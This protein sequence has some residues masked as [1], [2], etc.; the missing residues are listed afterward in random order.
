MD[1]DGD[2]NEPEW[3]YCTAEGC[4][5]AALPIW[6][7]GDFPDDPDLF[8]CIKHI[9]AEIVR[10]TEALEQAARMKTIIGARR[11]VADALGKEN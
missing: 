3:G 1:V 8:L 2:D 7:S 5:E 9:G 11:I 4:T 6:L 10:L